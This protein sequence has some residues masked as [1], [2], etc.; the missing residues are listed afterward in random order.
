MSK[1]NEVSKSIVQELEKILEEIDCKG[2][3]DLDQA[4]SNADRIFLGAA[5]RSKLVLQAFG[6]RLMH[7]GKTVYVVGD[8]TTPAIKKTDLLIIGSGSGE[9][10]GLVNMANQAKNI[11]SQILL[12]TTNAKSTIGLMAD[13]VILIKASTPKGSSTETFVSI[14]PGAS[15]FEQALLIYLDSFILNRM[16]NEELDLKYI[17]ERHANLE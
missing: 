2:G 9:T 14:Q 10:K 5:G 13:Y 12:I 1:I 11:E 6:M 7:L 15:L 16:I 4:I 17:M 8:V 3:E